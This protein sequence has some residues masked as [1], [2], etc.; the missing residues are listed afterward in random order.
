MYNYNFKGNNES[1]IKE[2]VNIN[3]KINKNYYQSNFVLTENNLLIFLDSNQG[4]ALKGRGVQFLPK[5]DLLFKISLKELKYNIESD[6]LIISVN[7]EKIN[8]Y[9]FDIEEFLR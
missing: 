9:D 7:D 2:A 3:I 8:C 6:N 4:N 1:L 5:Y